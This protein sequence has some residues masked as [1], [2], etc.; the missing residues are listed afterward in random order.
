MLS[1]D[2]RDVA[3]VLETTGGELLQTRLPKLTRFLILADDTGGI[4]SR[5]SGSARLASHQ[6]SASAETALRSLARIRGRGQ[7]PVRP[8]ASHHHPAG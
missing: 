6:S 4:P 1:R 5:A 7:G 3:K 8:D 2:A